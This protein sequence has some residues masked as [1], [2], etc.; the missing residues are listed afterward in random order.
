MKR[1]LKPRQKVMKTLVEVSMDLYGDTFSDLLLTL[2][3][4]ER[5]LYQSEGLSTGREICLRMGIP[6]EN[7]RQTESIKLSIYDD[8]AT[9]AFKNMIT[10]LGEREEVDGALVLDD[11][12]IILI[13]EGSRHIFYDRRTSR[14][15]RE[16]RKGRPPAGTGRKALLG[17]SMEPRV[18]GFLLSEKGRVFECRA[19][20]F[21]RIYYPK[22]GEIIH[23][24]KGEET[25]R[26]P[27]E[28]YDW[29]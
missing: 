22:T 16:R 4:P 29:R 17:I 26:F 24:K 2:N 18:Y 3:N 8:N 7:E 10:E 23:Y 14:K 20:F 6:L 9:D 12:G 28:S 13:G 21:R 27:V 1:K 19:G 11:N 5:V 25:G 15:L